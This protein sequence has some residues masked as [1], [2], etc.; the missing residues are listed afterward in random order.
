MPVMLRAAPK[1][2]GRVVGDHA[3]DRD[4]RGGKSRRAD[5]RGRHAEDQVVRGCEARLEGVD[6][7]GFLAVE[8]GALAVVDLVILADALAVTGK[9]GDQACDV[10]PHIARD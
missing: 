3:D 8:P 1:A 5:H 7:V 10:G 2:L 6:R 4:V 9:P